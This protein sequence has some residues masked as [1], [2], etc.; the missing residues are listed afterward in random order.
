[1]SLTLQ[2]LQIK[3]LNDRLLTQ[4][5]IIQTLINILIESELVTE[6]ELQT[7]IEDNL[8]GITGIKRVTSKSSENTSNVTI[9]INN[10][11]NNQFVLQEYNAGIQIG[12][13]SKEPQKFGFDFYG[14]LQNEQILNSDIRK[15]GV[16]IKKAYTGQQ[17]LLDVSSFYRVYVKEGTTEVQVQ[18]WTPINRTPNEYYFMF[19]MRDKLPNQYYVDIQVNTSGE[20]DT[21]KKQLT[22]NIVN[23][24]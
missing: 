2:R 6:K 7:K 1:M 5:V 12:T 9:E 17:M 23:K 18:D 19:D 4:N 14:I 22:F 11:A 20:K 8:D 21:Y 15:V 10:D 24:K 13:L 16:T 3:K